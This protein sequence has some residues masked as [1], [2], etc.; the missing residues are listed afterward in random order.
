MTVPKEEAD[1]Q[2]RRALGRLPGLQAV[3]RLPGR[4]AGWGAGGMAKRQPGERWWV[5]LRT[6]RDMEKRTKVNMVS[7]W[8]VTV[9]LFIHPRST[10]RQALCP[11]PSRQ[12]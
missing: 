1:N 8:K 11:A 4:W 7:S 3:A 2:Q 6:A 5:C 9:L 10:V 12:R